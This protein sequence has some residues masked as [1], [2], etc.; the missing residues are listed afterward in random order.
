MFTETW[1]AVPGYEGLYEASDMGRV[2]SLAGYRRWPRKEPRMMSPTFIS[3][4][5]LKTRLVDKDGRLKNFNIARMVAMAFLGLPPSPLH[6]VDHINENR[7][8]DRLGNIRWLTRSENQRRRRPETYVNKLRLPDEDI[9]RIKLL[10]AL[11]AK[12]CVLAQRYGVHFTTISKIKNGHR[13][14]K[15]W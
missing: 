6:E 7:A 4:G 5:Y 8:D 3:D 13:R 10:L 15:T 2:R 14:S 11:G 1:K 9:N 12:Q